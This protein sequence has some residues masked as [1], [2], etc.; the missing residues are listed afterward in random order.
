MKTKASNKSTYLTE[1]SIVSGILFFA[2]PLFI[3]NIFQQFYAVADSFI[4]S[5]A[6][7]VAAFAA[8]GSTAP[9]NALIPGFAMGVSSGFGIMISH[10]FGAKDGDGVRKNFF[11]GLFLTCALSI[12]LSIIF[13]PLTKPLLS[14]IQTPENLLQDASIYLRILFAGII[15]TTLYNYFLVAIRALG[16]SK[17]T[18]FFLIFSSLLNIALDIFF[19]MLLNWGGGWCCTVYNFCAAYRNNPLLYLYIKKNPHFSFIR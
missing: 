2:I 8:V 18:L 17:T 9:L 14:L 7:G 13:V 5:R 12:T 19:V 10:Y 11:S 16:N 1:G 3:G 15:V 6:L 4:V